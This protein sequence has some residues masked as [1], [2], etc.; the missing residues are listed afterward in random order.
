MGIRDLLQGLL[1]KPA[2]LAELRDALAALPAPGRT[3][4][5]EVER[6]AVGVEYRR[7]HA[8]FVSTDARLKVETEEASRAVEL[9]QANV[10]RLAEETSVSACSWT[11]WRD[12]TGRRAWEMRPALVDQLIALVREEA[13]HLRAD[14]IGLPAAALKGWSPWNYSGP[15]AVGELLDPRSRLEDLPHGVTNAESVDARRAALRALA[16]TIETWTCCGA[17]ATKDDLQGLFDK[18][19]RSLPKVESLREVLKRDPRGAQYIT[20]LPSATV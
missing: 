17:Y 10:S 12:A 16:E 7:R 11:A 3:E 8:E 2:E 19:Y 14:G 6:R 18:A 9:A 1:G 15:A 20:A 13:S 5:P 4:M